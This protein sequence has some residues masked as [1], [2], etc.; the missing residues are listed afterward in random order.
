MKQDDD[1]WLN[2]I[3]CPRHDERAVGPDDE[4][5]EDCNKIQWEALADSQI[6]AEEEELA[7]GAVEWANVARITVKHV[8]ANV[9]ELADAY[10]AGH[11]R[12]PG[13]NGLI[14]YVRHNMTNYDVLLA[15]L[16]KFQASRRGGPAY[17][18]IRQRVDE[19]V[20]LEL[21]RDA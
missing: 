17:Q 1:A 18:I 12:P 21:D 8:P 6:E 11:E 9:A 3:R 7:S 14:A 10:F 19:Q 2:D 13:R 20:E 16:S 15:E 5:C 4:P